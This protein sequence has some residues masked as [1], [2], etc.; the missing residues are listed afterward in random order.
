MTTEKMHYCL[1]G[2]GTIKP[3]HPMW[4]RAH[5][6][7]GHAPAT[8]GEA[9]AAKCR[10]YQQTIRPA[11]RVI[12]CARCGHATGGGYGHYTSWCRITNEPTEPH[13]CCPTSCALVDG[14]EMDP[15][16]PCH[17]ARGD[18]ERWAQETDAAREKP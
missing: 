11:S 4:K 13:Q 10:H 7:D 16:G 1:C 6:G 5:E 3:D 2:E 8:E 9:A 15:T 18:Y 12:F 14:S 17:P